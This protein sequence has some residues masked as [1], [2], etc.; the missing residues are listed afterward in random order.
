MHKLHIAHKFNAFSHVVLF[1]I[2][3]VIFNSCN[4]FKDPEPE[5]EP[6]PTA[7]DY[8][9]AYFYQY[10][11]WYDQLPEVDPNSYEN[12]DYLINDII[13]EQDR[14]SYA[15]SYERISKLL[16]AAESKSFGS[17]F[18]I[19]QE[20]NIRVI[21]VYAQSPF[22]VYGVKRGWIVESI[23][24]YGTD[25]LDKLNE[26]LNSEGA[27][28]FVFTDHHGEKHTQS[29][30]KETFSMNTVLFSNT[31]EMD[32]KKIGYVV[33]D[34]FYETSEEELKTVF[35]NFS[36]ENITNLIVD[37]RYNGGG[38]S[39]IA[40][41]LFGMIGGDKVDGQLMYS[42]MHNDKLTNY[43]ESVSSTYSGPS[44]NIDHVHFITTDQSAS[45][46]ELVINSLIPYMD[47]TLIGSDTHGKPVGMYVLHE[48]DLDLAILPVAFINKNALGYGEFFDGLP[49]DIL[50]Y[51]DPTHDWGDLEEGMLKAAI[52]AIV[53]PDVISFVPKSAYIEKPKL[54]NPH[55][56]N[57]LVKYK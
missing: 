14:W 24:G 55:R 21:Y 35:Q 45:A 13:V 6:D 51:D 8:V 19:D 32:D 50:V 9:Y 4:W 53:E 31:Y 20:N 27:V 7:N 23:N 46:S 5:P 10:Y 16:E 18:I 37:L 22:G 25:N 48:D 2:M 33:F 11:L 34:G 38:I 42:Q 47:V 36:E 3:A 30:T 43:D 1:L 41:M 49:S 15:T 26:A 40:E 56:F 12:Y 29:F 57:H 17:W 52:G 28:E 39:Q 54:I 44:V